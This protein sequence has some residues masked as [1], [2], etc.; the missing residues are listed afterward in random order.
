MW[1]PKAFLG[2]AP[3]RGAETKRGPQRFAETPGGYTDTNIPVAIVFQELARGNMLHFMHSTAF[4]LIANHHLLKHW[5][6][7][8][9]QGAGSDF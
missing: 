3:I 7:T 1:P 9:A 5:S 2:F 6:R 8:S 4:L